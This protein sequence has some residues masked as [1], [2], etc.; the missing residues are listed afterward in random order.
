MAHGVRLA[1][2]YAQATGASP[3]LVGP[4]I[5]KTIIDVKLSFSCRLRSNASHMQLPSRALIHH[6]GSDNTKVN[7]STP[8]RLR[9]GQPE[10]NIYLA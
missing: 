3:F 9:N 7:Y 8:L 4:R 5:S 1:H 2:A 6:A 10:I